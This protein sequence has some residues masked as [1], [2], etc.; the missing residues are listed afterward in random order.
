MVNDCQIININ[1]EKDLGRLIDEYYEQKPCP[2]GRKDRKGSIDVESQFATPN[3]ESS[4][5]ASLWA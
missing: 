1:R 5:L 4:E 3:E 2:L